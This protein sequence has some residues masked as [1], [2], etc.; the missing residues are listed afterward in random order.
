LHEARAT[1]G[2]G[3]MASA[4]PPFKDRLGWYQ[5]YLERRLHDSSVAVRLA[6]PVSVEQLVA[7]HPDLVMLAAG[8]QP[9]AMSIEGIAQPFVHDAYDLLM[10]DPPWLPAPGSA[11]VLVYGGGETGCETAE[12][13]AER[14][15]D[16]LLVTRSSRA[17]LACSAEMIYRAVLLQRLQD[18]PRIRIVDH[19]QL[20]RIA[21][22][23]RIGWRLADQA[24][25]VECRVSRVLIA[26]DRRPDPHWGGRAGGRRYRLRGHWRRAPR[27][28][29]GDAVQDAYRALCGRCANAMV[30]AEA[31][32]LAC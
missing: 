32:A 14:G 30:P 22:D 24:D 27:W 25:E 8:A 31:A 4:A 21:S 13:V 20:L 7:D 6:S 5:R 11:P 23:G 26:Q 9:L 3:L 12:H 18:N 17:D 28:T 29:L 16:V 15:F 1:L 2:G 10:G 19:A